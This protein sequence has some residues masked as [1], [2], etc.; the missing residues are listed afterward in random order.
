M[1]KAT[2]RSS[3]KKAEERR[4]ST[5]GDFKFRMGGIM[6]LPSGL[7]VKTR[8]PGGLKAFI[9][10]GDIP[11]SL[12]TIIKSSL[13][14]GKTPNTEDFLKDGQLDA[15]MIEDMDTMMNNM[16]V[17]IIVEPHISPVPESEDERADDQVYA[18]EIP[19]DD[20]MFLFQWVSGGTRDLEKFRKQYEQSVDSVARSTSN[21][22]TAQSAAGLDPR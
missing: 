6:E 3:E 15:K 10:G 20:K 7:V 8:N 9:A 4:I 13:D 11:N 18:D 16:V 22:R 2:T 21:V 5:I 19:T 14:K 1:A 12:M 17:Q